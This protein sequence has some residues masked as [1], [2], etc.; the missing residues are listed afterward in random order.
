MKGV[1]ELSAHFPGIESWTESDFERCRL[2]RLSNERFD[3]LVL[4]LGV[5]ASLGAD[6]ACRKLFRWLEEEQSDTRR[7]MLLKAAGGCPCADYPKD[8]LEQLVK[9]PYTD[10]CV[11][12]A[13]LLVKTGDEGERAVLALLGSLSKYGRSLCLGVLTYGTG[14]LDVEAVAAYANDADSHIRNAALYTLAFRGDSSCTDHLIAPLQR[15][16]TLTK[17]AALHALICVGDDR[18]VDAVLHRYR[19]DSARRADGTTIVWELELNYL[20]QQSA[21]RPD[22]FAETRSVTARHWA[23]RDETEVAW[24]QAHLPQL[25]P[26]FRGQFGPLTEARRTQLRH[27]VLSRL[28]RDLADSAL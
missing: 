1:V 6:W 2:G 13:Y 12:A 21:A 15:R 20:G 3:D 28:Q 5:R 19:L 18:A 9:V 24:I 17:E 14:T 4:Q 25:A 11:E 26:D 10:I 7:V 16:D 27:T 23:K 22:A 8:L